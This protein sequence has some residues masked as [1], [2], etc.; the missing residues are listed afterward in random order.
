MFFMYICIY[1]YIYIYF[2]LFLYFYAL[3]YMIYILSFY[4]KLE[5]FLKNHRR[6]T[7]SRDVSPTLYKLL[8]PYGKS[9]VDK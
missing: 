4:Y 8:F 7:M 5:Q 9:V 1:V 3:Y 6:A 2:F